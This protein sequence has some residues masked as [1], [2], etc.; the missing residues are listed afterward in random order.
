MTY[1]SGD[2]GEGCFAGRPDYRRT[3]SYQDSQRVHDSRHALS[4]ARSLGYCR[5]PFT[6]T[7]GKEMP[8]GTTAGASPTL[9]EL[10]REVA[11][12]SQRL[13]AQREEYNEA[14]QRE[15]AVGEIL[16]IVNAASGDLT[17]IFQAI[18]EKAME[19]C[20]ASFGGLWIFD[21]GRYVVRALHG[22]P[23]AYEEF[24]HQTTVLPG[25]GSAPD[26]FLRGERSVFQNIDLADEKPY[27]DGDPQRRALVDLGG[28]RTAL[29]AP[30][31]K[32]DG[33][34]GVMTI[35]RQKVEPFDDRQ[36][37]L[38][39]TFAA[40]AVVAIENARLLAECA[41]ASS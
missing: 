28:A 14:L 25:P 1:A 18:L 30:L 36:I 4:A 22:V 27:H 32:D 26:R 10:Q 3:G 38:L 31:C 12:L 20:G 15:A 2:A 34:V 37:A 7:R 13:R 16:R 5:D 33:V 24:L 41:T 23:R 19:L 17:P 29:Q 40:Q 35:Y 8:A 9:S 11:E 6:G 39:Q 21:A